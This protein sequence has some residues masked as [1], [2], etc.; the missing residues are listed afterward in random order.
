MARKAEGGGPSTRAPPGAEGKFGQ[1]SASLEDL[2]HFSQPGGDESQ[3]ST[4]DGA[5]EESSRADLGGG[6]SD[7]I[8]G[9]S[10][11]PFEK[12]NPTA[13]EEFDGVFDVENV[14]VSDPTVVRQL[15]QVVVV[16][17]KAEGLVVMVVDVEVVVV[18]KVNSSCRYS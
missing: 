12:D 1:R 18:V 15:M 16:T 14:N 7:L 2:A 9:G 10:F 13:P 3:S 6:G 11:N 8:D 17:W 4:N 5:G